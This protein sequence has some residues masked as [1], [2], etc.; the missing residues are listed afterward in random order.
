MNY[1]K[2]DST[3]WAGRTSNQQLYFHE[4]VAFLDFENEQLKPSI[5][6]TF[7]FLGYACDEGVWRNQGR[8]GAV[9]GPDAI[10]KV[11]AKMP[12]HMATQTVF[13][14]VGTLT[15]PDHGLETIQTQLA[16]CVQQ[17]LKNNIFP[18]LVGGG[19]DI[20]YGHFNGIK[21]H[22]GNEKTI[23]II[24]FDAHF[25]L[26]SNEN[27]NN[28][29]TPFFQIAKDCKSNVTAFKYLCLGIRKDAND[30]VLFKTANDL[31]VTYIENTK[32][33]ANYA[34]HV[35]RVVQDFIHEVD[36]AYVTIDLD[37]F[38]SAY[39]PGVSAPSPMGFSPGIV[40]ETLQMIIDSKKLISIDIAEMNP[41]YDLDGQ[42]AKLAAS[43][44]HFV[45][46]SY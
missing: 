10:R 15:C 23:G 41:K 39:A 8:P 30:Q 13:L 45:L 42:T 11:L 21:N 3:L 38:S 14:D 12:N 40:L 18:I 37:G 7:A 22:L 19:H 43:L 34:A 35:V 28:S 20:A 29:G 5:D 32:F 9:D 17:L 31:G 2:P 36:H 16:E 1:N 44:V 24:N 4:K 26:R 33:R 46:H 25:D 6:V 27:G